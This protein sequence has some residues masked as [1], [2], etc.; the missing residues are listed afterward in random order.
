MYAAVRNYIHFG[1]YYYWWR[2]T[3]E[4]VLVIPLVV[5]SG[6]DRGSDADGGRGQS[7]GRDRR[8]DAGRL[9]GDN[10]RQLDHAVWFGSHLDPAVG[11]LGGS[12]GGRGGGLFSCEGERDFL[13]GVGK[14]TDKR[15]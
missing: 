1:V 15:Y 10:G 14:N 12:G 8:D 4:L 11:G 9:G 7:R 5:I 6:F 3:F 2:V 13:Y